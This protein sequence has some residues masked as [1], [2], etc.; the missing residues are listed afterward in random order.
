MPLTDEE[1]IKKNEERIE[2][3]RLD[4]ARRKK[5]IAEKKRKLETRRKIIAG[6]VVLKH[7]KV[8]ENF[9]V[10]LQELFHRFVEERDRS[11]FD[12]PSKKPEEG[13]E[14]GGEDRPVS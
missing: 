2:K 3:L 1:R 6:S 11:L 14:K 9:Q 4:N 13:K 5:K 12:L 7:A 10:A 8:D